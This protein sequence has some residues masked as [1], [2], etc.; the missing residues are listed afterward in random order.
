[1]LYTGAVP[2]FSR[3][4]ERLN[5]MPVMGSSLKWTVPPLQG[6]TIWLC[7]VNELSLES[8]YRPAC[9]PRTL[10]QIEEEEAAD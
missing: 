3:Q 7:V 6:S 4:I 10:R 8:L 1:M 9:P 2:W 5:N